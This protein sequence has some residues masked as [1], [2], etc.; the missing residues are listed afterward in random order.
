MI[1]KTALIIGGEGFIGRN[2][3]DVISKTHS[4]SSIGVEKSIFSN[5]EDVFIKNNPYKDKLYEKFDIYIHLIDNSV[6]ENI[7]EIEEEK[8]IDNLQIRSESHLIIF[9][10]AAI[11]ANP[12]SEYA[13]RKLKLESF[14]K[15]YCKNNNIK[16][17]ILRLFNT[18]GKYQ[19]P[20]KQGSLVANIFYNYLNNL[21]IEINDKTAMRDFIYASDIGKIVEHII[22]N[23]EYGMMD[24]GTEECISIENL[25]SLIQEKILQK[26]VK[27][28]YKNIKENIIQHPAT[29]NLHKEIKQTSLLEG[30]KKTFNFYNEN[31][32]II[33][34]HLNEK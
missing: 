10:S 21:P 4:C 16:L 11:Y 17:T 22:E 33:N 6:S 20:Y 34:K 5:R 1:K 14:Y 12:E 3:A 9:S 13:K 29:G 27:V 7:F 23:K 19:L 18:Y 25:L 24:L 8:L 31:K 2:I 26:K 30:L 28:N 32:E 15:N